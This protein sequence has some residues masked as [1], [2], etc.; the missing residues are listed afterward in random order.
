[1]GNTSQVAM[2]DILKDMV[3]DIRSM[4]AVVS[5]LLFKQACR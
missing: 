4:H 2:E 1:V 3:N 5:V